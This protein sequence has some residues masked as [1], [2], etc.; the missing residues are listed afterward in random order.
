MEHLKDQR[1]NRFAGIVYPNIG[2]E[3]EDQLIED[4]SMDKYHA[5]RSRMSSTGIRKMLKSPKH[6]R[7]WLAG[8]D[9]ED[10]EKEHFRYGR[11]VHMFLLEPDKFH[12]RHLI[13]PDFGAMQSSKNRERRKAWREDQDPEAVIIT[14][15]ELDSLLDIFDSL[16]EHDQAGQMLRN[17]KP[18]VT[19]FW[20]HKETGVHCRV[21]PDY[22]STDSDGNLYVIDIKTTRNANPGLFSTDCANYGYHVQLAYYHDGVAQIMGR[23]PTSAAIIAIEKSV[24]YAVHVYWLDEKWLE[25]GRIEY[26]RALRKFVECMEKSE[27]LGPQGSGVILSPP[28]WLT[29]SQP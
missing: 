6:F 18:E 8:A 3:H 5:D 22:L 14:E 12:S 15:K 4:Y 9:D 28:G 10:E 25:V 11:A 23:E 16:S 1:R 20:K 27:W 29:G 13:E 26:E 24:P 2:G 19:G 21:R 17:G 7:A